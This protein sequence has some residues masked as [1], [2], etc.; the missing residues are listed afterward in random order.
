MSKAQGVILC[1]RDGRP[2]SESRMFSAS[3]ELNANDKR[4]AFAQQSN[5]MNMLRKGEIIQ[6][7]A[8]ILSMS[9]EQRDERRRDRNAMFHEA[10][11]D[12]TGQKWASLGSSVVGKIENQMERA[13]LMRSVLMNGGVLRMGEAAQWRLKDNVCGAV[14]ASGPT[15]VG[16][17][18]LRGKVFNPQE[19]EMLANV[20]VRRLDMYQVGGDLLDEAQSDVKSS[21]VTGEDRLLIKALDETVGKVHPI[22]YLHG[23]LAPEN[24]SAMRDNLDSYNIPV[25]ATMLSSDF[26]TDIVGSEVWMQALEPVTKYE[27]I[28]TGRLASLL[29]MD[30]ITDGFRDPTQR[31]LNRGTIYTL[32]QPEYLGGY[33]TRG[34]A[35]VQATDGANEGNTDKGW[36]ISQ[37]QTMLIGNVKSVVKAVRQ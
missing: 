27:L 36:L 30:L 21:L 33:T 10:V 7:D 12:A 25:A 32:G 34:G 35:T 5:L 13:G 14:V 6:A 17:Q 37:V 22:T 2:L 24:L 3:G 11:S 28:T 26:W 20:R 23:L 19:F 15:N 1:T 29:G 8:E 31:V 18:V 4:D 16:Y 9:S